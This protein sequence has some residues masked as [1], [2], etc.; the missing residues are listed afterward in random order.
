MSVILIKIESFYKIPAVRMKSMMRWVTY[1]INQNII[2]KSP[3]KGKDV[4]YI[5]VTMSVILIE[6]EG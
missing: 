4:I 6:I 5:L 1:L 3:Q 2:C